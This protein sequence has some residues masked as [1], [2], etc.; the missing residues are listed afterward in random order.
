[1]RT[2][3]LCVEVGLVNGAIGTV[4]AICYQQ[5]SPPDLPMA[6]MYILAH[7]QALHFR[8]TLYLLFHNVEAGYTVALLAIGCSF[9]L[10]YPGE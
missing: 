8:T 4:I 10:N 7:I 2:S 6:V 3:N 9:L 1:M 5:G